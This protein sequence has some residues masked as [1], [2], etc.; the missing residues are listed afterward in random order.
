M[1][2]YVEDKVKNIRNHKRRMTGTG[3]NRN[4]FDTRS[5]QESYD[6]KQI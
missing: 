3:S 6:E 1:E 5:A 4:E 2:T